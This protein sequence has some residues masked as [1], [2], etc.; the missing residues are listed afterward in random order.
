ML[1]PRGG[2]A[3]SQTGKTMEGTWWTGQGEGRREHG[4]LKKVRFV[5]RRLYREKQDKRMH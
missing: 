2:L 1:K 5:E 3:I 4:S